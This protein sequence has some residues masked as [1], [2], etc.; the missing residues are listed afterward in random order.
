MDG[1]KLM[2]AL[3]I[4]ALL[5]YGAYRLFF[6]SRV[7]I[8][9]DEI[10]AA[11]DADNRA[12]FERKFAALELKYV[13]MGIIAK[14]SEWR[15]V[16]KDEPRTGVKLVQIPP[17][18]FDEYERA[19]KAWNKVQLKLSLFPQALRPRKARTK[20]PDVPHRVITQT[21]GSMMRRNDEPDLE[22]R[23]L[24]NSGP[25]I[26]EAEQLDVET[27]AAR[28]NAPDLCGWWNA[29]SAGVDI[30]DLESRGYLPCTKERGHSGP[31]AHPHREGMPPFDSSPEM[32]DHS[33]PDENSRASESPSSDDTRSTT[34]GAPTTAE[35][36]E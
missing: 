2:G 29:S 33:R 9:E 19:F 5:A 30:E 8:T 17:S 6:S 16:D 28:A 21:S 12:T 36:E 10:V 25:L 27:E 24:G 13:Q 31:C 15:L 35:G 7:R 26:P 3:A 4:V 14:G 18:L 11:I 1:L 23:I 22:E 34:D 32:I 20:K